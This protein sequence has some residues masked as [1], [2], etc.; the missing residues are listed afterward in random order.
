MAAGAGGGEHI[1][2]VLRREG[3]LT[4]GGGH[5][6]ADVARAA[7]THIGAQIEQAS[8]LGGI[9]QAAASLGGMRTGSQLARKVF[10]RGERRL[11]HKPGDDLA[12]FK[13]GKAFVVHRFLKSAPEEGE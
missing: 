8:R 4:H 2:Q 11:V 10:A 7:H 9:V 12:V 13:S 5:L 3:R 6:G 1:E